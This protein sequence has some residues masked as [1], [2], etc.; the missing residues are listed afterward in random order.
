MM[1]KMPTFVPSQEPTSAPVAMASIP[2]PP[3]LPAGMPLPPPPMATAAPSPPQ[4]PYQQQPQQQPAAVVYP[5]DYLWTCPLCELP[6]V[7]NFTLHTDKDVLQALVERIPFEYLNRNRRDST[8]PEGLVRSILHASREALMSE[9]LVLQ[10]RAP[11][12]IC[13]DIHG[14]LEDLL[15]MFAR[16]PPLR[17]KV[18]KSFAKPP[19]RAKIGTSASAPAFAPGAANNGKEEAA[20]QQPATPSPSPFRS[21]LFLGDYVD[22]GLFSIEVML[23]LLCLKLI[24]PSEMHLL[25]GNHESMAISKRYGFFDECKRRYPSS[26]GMWKVFTDLFLCLPVAAI[27]GEAVFC[28]HGGISP[29]LESVQQ[30]ICCPDPRPFETPSSGV[31]CDLLWSDPVTDPEVMSGWSSNERGVSYCWGPD[32]LDMFLERNGLD[33]LCRGHQVMEE[34][35]GFFPAIEGTAGKEAGRKAVTVFSASDYGGEFGNCGAMMLV[36]EDLR[37][38]F[39]VFR[40]PV[41]GIKNILRTGL[42]SLEIDAVLPLVC[43]LA[44]TVSEGDSPAVEQ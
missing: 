24:S 6:N 7:N 39:H 20:D 34:G 38:G 17:G 30:L 22:R 10:L 33:L 43:K 4:F 41:D 18:L 32:V 31:F 9:P 40:N 16:E 19:Q 27:V 21:Y 11:M 14:Q 44:T 29:E 25:R 37:C 36:S 8:I 5:K 42:T 12:N 3:P 15:N 13:G 26:P 28:C 1:K 2:T 35:Y 23:L